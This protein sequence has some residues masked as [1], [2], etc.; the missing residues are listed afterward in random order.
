[1][2]GGEFL[3][4]VVTSR[5][6]EVLTNISL[7]QLDTENHIFETLVSFR[8]RMALIDDVE[9]ERGIPVNYGII[10]LYFAFKP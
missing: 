6:I 3:I 7:Y 8:H 9:R 1:L 5:N 4:F 10:E 2:P